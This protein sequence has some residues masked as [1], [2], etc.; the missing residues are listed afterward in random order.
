MSLIYITGVEGSGK[1][2]VAYELRRL[3]YEAIDVDSS[4]LS[5]RY[6][7][8]SWEASKNLPEPHESHV[9]WYQEREWKIKPA[10]IL[11]I[12]MEPGDKTVF[13]CGITENFVE[14]M[15][16]FTKVICLV[17]H[18]A[19]VIERIN[20]RVNNDF[21][22]DPAQLE[23]ILAKHRQY[24][25]LLAENGAL[26]IDATKPLSEVVSEIVGKALSGEDVNEKPSPR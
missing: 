21:G 3:G 6:I 7:K 14:I 15:P 26:M 16:Y 4:K 9:S 12:K 1:S 19:G 5:R 23:Y 20:S 2:T 10:D 22:K 17:L 18:K 13:L 8:G 24:E 11:R 25:S